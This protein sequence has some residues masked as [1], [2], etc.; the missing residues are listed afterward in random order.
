MKD[1]L[2]HATQAEDQVLRTMMRNPR[3]VLSMQASDLAKIGYCSSST[4]VRLCRKLGFQG[5]KELK[6]ALS[7]ELG[8]AARIS[9][10]SFDESLSLKEM[11]GL[12]LER[13]RSALSQT[14]SLLDFDEIEKIASVITKSPVIHLYGIGASYLVAQD[15]QMKLIR[16]KKICCL[17][18]DL[19]LQLVDA[20][21]VTAGDVCM[22]ISY[23]G[24]TREMIRAAEAIKKNGGILITLTKYSDN[25]L[26][27]LAD[28]RLYVPSTEDELRLFA[29]SSR[30]CQ[31]SVIDI[32]FSWI[33]S[34]NYEEDMLRIVDSS[35]TL[36]KV[37]MENQEGSEQFALENDLEGFQDDLSGSKKEKSPEAAE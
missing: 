27:S 20:G 33:M 14:Y 9:T 24:Q 4:V 36:K 31:M 21:N 32:L 29:G 18:K 30:L 25:R 34:M 8:Y 19:H 15:F 7:E 11:A 13:Y 26:A 10:S 6:L 17:D 12:Q 37:P 5:L 22:I 3:E 2:P 35:T 28:Y 16:V 1:Y 23:S